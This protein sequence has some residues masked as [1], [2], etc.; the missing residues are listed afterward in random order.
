MG[1]PDFP[2]FPLGMFILPG[3]RVKLQIFEPRY[4]DMISDRMRR[5][6]TFGVVQIREGHEVGEAPLFFPVGTEV[7][8][9]DFSQQ[10]NGLL[11]IE[12]LG[13]RRFKVNTSRVQP[14]Q[15]LMADVEW[16]AD[17]GSAAI[18]D[19]VE[20]LNLLLQKLRNHPGVAQ[21]QL[22][23]ADTL[24]QLG[25]Q[26]SLLLP[27]SLPEKMQLWETPDPEQRLDMV[28]KHVDQLS[29]R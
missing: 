25:W 3:Q 24:S 27:L 14:D 7:A 4:L 15:L 20:K 13:Q 11:G 23:D 5:G 6:A 10:E 28:A 29:G 12:I 18:S 26:L 9:V 1:E 16:L 22:P 19:D 8:I 21:L 2:L 17:E